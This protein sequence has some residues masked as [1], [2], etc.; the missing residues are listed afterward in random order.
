MRTE[1]ADGAAGAAHTGECPSAGLPLSWLA[2]DDPADPSIGPLIIRLGRT[3]GAFK[4]AYEAAIGMSPPEGWL[5]AILAGRDGLT[6][7][8]LAGM[9]HVDPSMVTR[10]VKE[11][12][13]TRGWIR[14]ERDPADNRLMRVYLTDEGRARTSGLADRAMA[15][16]RRL[17]R[18]LSDEQARGLRRM[19]G[20]LEEAAR[21]ETAA[22]GRASSEESG[23]GG[24]ER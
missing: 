10:I 12:E 15:L 16:E 3:L 13:G 17:T 8:E 21:A 20:A 24:A 18:A 2:P 7:N 9:V 14:R 11:L 5:L 19:L 1:R 4:A 23:A 22:G 6:Q